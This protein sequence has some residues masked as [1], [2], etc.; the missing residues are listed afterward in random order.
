MYT[1]SRREIRNPPVVPCCTD[2]IQWKEWQF[3]EE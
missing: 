3:D 2:V 1:A